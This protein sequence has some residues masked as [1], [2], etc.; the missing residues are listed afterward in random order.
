MRLPEPGDTE[1]G[2]L[3]CEEWPPTPCGHI[4]VL[5]VWADYFEEAALDTLSPWHCWA[6]MLSVSRIKIPSAP[7]C[8]PLEC[9]KKLLPTSPE[10]ADFEKAILSGSAAACSAAAGKQRPGV[11]V[12]LVQCGTVADPEPCIEFY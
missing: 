7:G 5:A 9:G 4:L 1:L 3:A 10:L 6:A 8:G 2:I 12:L 11:L